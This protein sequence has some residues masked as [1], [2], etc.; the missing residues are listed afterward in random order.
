MHAAVFRLSLDRA[1]TRRHCVF[2]KVGVR[3]RGV[4]DA[5]GESLS[6]FSSF[7]LWLRVATAVLW[8]GVKIDA[9]GAVKLTKFDPQ[10]RE[11]QSRPE[12]LLLA[13]KA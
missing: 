2:C 7:G 1:D 9:R 11:W 4:Q 3:R 12:I 8:F 6:W 13:V 10:G 5:S